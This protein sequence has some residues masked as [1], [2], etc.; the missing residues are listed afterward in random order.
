MSNQRRKN[1]AHEGRD[2]D[3]EKMTLRKNKNYKD[4]VGYIFAPISQDELKYYCLIICTVVGTTLTYFVPN[5]IST[6]CISLLSIILCIFIATFIWMWT[7]LPNYKRVQF[8]ERIKDA[9]TFGLHTYLRK[10]NNYDDDDDSGSVGLDI[11]NDEPARNLIK[12]KF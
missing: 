4:V 10:T 3:D 12:H 8:V 7:I 9:F 1:V 5:I 2:N 11:D 6:I